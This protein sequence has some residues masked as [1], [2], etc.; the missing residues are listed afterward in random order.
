M[1]KGLFYHVA[2][3]VGHVIKKNETKNNY[4][5]RLRAK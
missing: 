5:T 3:R 1:L 4:T 2:L